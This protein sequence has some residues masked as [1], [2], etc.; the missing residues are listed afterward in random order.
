MSKSL[1]FYNVIFCEH[2]VICRFLA[3]P[4]PGLVFYKN[5]IEMEM[6]I[7]SAAS[8]ANLVETRKL[9]EAALSTYDQDAS[10]W[11]DYHSM[12]SKVKKKKKIQKKNIFET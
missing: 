9:Y 6:N 11:Q 7:A 8:K 1:N 12:E 3:L 4:R 10:L 2:F 5:C